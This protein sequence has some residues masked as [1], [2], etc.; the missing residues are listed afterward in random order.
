MFLLLFVLLLLPFFNKG[1][2][3]ILFLLPL[4]SLELF[5]LIFKECYWILVSGISFSELNINFSCSGI[6][7]SLEISEF[8]SLTK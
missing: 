4:I 1:F 7:T 3:E 6:D 2:K 5:F 8:S